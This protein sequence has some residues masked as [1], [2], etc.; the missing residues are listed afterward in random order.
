MT[1]IKHTMTQ[2]DQL[3]YRD[4]MM[5]LQRC[6]SNWLRE[7]DRNTK[8]FHRKAVWRPKK[9]H[10]KKLKRADGSWCSKDPEMQDMALKYIRSCF[11][12]GQT[13]I[14]LS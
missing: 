3:L 4:E 2:M 6:R 13:F 14:R 12:G 8:F 5:W 10:I 11:L 7:G 9:N 1:E